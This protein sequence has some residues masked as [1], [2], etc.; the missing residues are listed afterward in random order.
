[1]NNFATIYNL[2]NFI[3]YLPSSVSFSKENIYQHLLSA[4]NVLEKNMA[5]LLFVSI[6][7]DIIATILQIMNHSL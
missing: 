3:D 5:I 1:M 6:S 4:I 7:P 2:L